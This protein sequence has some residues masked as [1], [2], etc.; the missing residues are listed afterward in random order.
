MNPPT[1]FEV[2]SFT[3]CGDMKGAENAQKG[4]VRG[5]P[6]SSLMSPF[7]RAPTTS[8][9][10]LI[11]AMRPFCTVLEIQRVICRNSPTLPYPTCTWHPRWGMTPFEFRKDFWQQ[12]TRVPGLSCSIVCVIISVA[13][14]IQYRHRLVPDGQTDTRRWLIPR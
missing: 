9:S 13:V 5:D 8:Y 11:E 7:D 3:R 4:V 6:R 10:S 12:K 1:K 14:L 2:F